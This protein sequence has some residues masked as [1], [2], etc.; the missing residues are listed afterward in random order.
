MIALRNA[1][2][3]PDERVAPFLHEFKIDVDLIKYTM[4]PFL[5]RQSSSNLQPVLYGLLPKL[6]IRRQVQQIR[7]SGRSSAA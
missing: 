3:V 7:S 4:N 2:L 1:V 5:F 6:L